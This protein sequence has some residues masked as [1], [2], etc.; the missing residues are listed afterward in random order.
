MSYT[1]I[2]TKKNGARYMYK[3]E[4]YWD[5][6]KKAPR[7]KQVCLGRIDDKTGEVIPSNRKERTAKRAA[8]APEVTAR[9]TVIGPSLLLDKVAG[10]T[11]LLAA[12]KK[13]LPGQFLRIIA[14]AY[15]LV[16]KGLPLSRCDIWSASNRH[17]YV[18]TIT[19]QSVS[20]LLRSVTESERQ[21]F[22]KTWMAR[23][24][25]SEN[26]FYDITSISS[27][28]EL[29]EYIK[30]LHNRD[31]EK[32]PQINL[33]MLF[34]Q[35]SG[36][37]LYYRRLPGSISD[38]S[39]LK[40][41]VSSLDKIGQ[42]KLTFVMDRGFYSE[43]NVDALFDARYSF[44][45]AVPKRKWIE[46]L[47]DKYRDEIQS[48]ENVHKTGEHET[49]YM[50]TYLHKWKDHRCYVH[51]YYNDV[52]A[53]EERSKFDGKLAAW[54]DELVSKSEKAENT[55]VYKKYF[56]VKDTP[57]RG[58]SVTFNE[59]AILKDRKKYAG[60]F[61]LMSS[62]KMDALAALE[63]Y[64]RKEAVENSFDDLKNQLDMKRLRIQSS[65]AMDSRLFIQFIALILLSQIR[66]IAKKN[67]ALKHKTIREIMEAMETVTE[68]IY[69][70]KYGKIVTEIDP[71]QRDIMEAFGVSIET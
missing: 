69:S 60:F 20:E 58:R 14:L 46:E 4:G 63:A 27:Y 65:A 61:C 8:V 26:I 45:L 10:D 40:T 15:F 54:R 21:M 52:R 6:E 62:K 57:A 16:Q 59:E 68:I 12:L 29:N 38:V 53:A 41:T 43:S 36:L 24:P 3:V 42:S 37:P 35:D 17:P 64:R 67:E 1:T 7:N 11:G 9:S 47:Y 70:G 50:A 31:D 2:H 49:L 34:G 28:S 55:A 19:S 56:I 5:K 22:F 32:M 48:H 66:N 51:I 44:L 13:S 25:E 23:I 33:A 18:E 71:L 39:T 30:C